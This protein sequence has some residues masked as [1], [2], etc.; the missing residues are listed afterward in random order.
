MIS[1]VELFDGRKLCAILVEEGRAVLDPGAHQK[2]VGE[3][4]I[5]K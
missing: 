5:R 3:I 2:G 1:S 4:R